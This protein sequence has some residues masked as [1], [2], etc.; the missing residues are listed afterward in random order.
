MRL[1]DFG[2][3]NASGGICVFAVFGILLSVEQI[4]C[5]A[6][7]LIACVESVCMCVSLAHLPSS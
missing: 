3:V 2:Y 1:S 5:L 4:L 7:T 6:E